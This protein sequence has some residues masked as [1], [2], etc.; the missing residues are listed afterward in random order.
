MKDFQKY[1]KALVALIAPIVVAIGARYGLELSPDEAGLLVALVTGL[2]VYLVPN[3]QQPDH[4]IQAYIKALEEKA[5]H[6]GHLT[7]HREE[8]N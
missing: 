2:A 3:K 8:E 6:T 4:D 1:N 7:I 5:Q